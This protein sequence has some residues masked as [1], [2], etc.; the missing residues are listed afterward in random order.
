[1]ETVA[2]WVLIGLGGIGLWFSTLDPIFGG[3]EMAPAAL[4]MLAFFTAIGFVGTLLIWCW[5]AAWDRWFHRMPPGENA[6]LEAATTVI[7]L[8]YLGAGVLMVCWIV[9]AR[10]GPIAAGSVA[11]SLAVLCLLTDIVLHHWLGRR[12]DR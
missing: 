11:G 2:L 1:V 8:A 6:R 9:N 10:L 3:P 12:R 5:P 4:T 7:H